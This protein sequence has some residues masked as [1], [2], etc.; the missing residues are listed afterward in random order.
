VVGAL[1]HVA[2]HVERIAWLDNHWKDVLAAFDVDSAGSRWRV[3]G[4]IVLSQELISPLLTTSPLRVIAF[5]D[6][7]EDPT[8]AR[9][10]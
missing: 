4:M 10:G 7:E 3:A 6:L 8:L 5:T 1:P 2:H 9:I